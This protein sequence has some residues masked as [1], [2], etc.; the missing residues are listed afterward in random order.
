MKSDNPSTL[1]LAPSWNAASEQFRLTRIQ[2][3]NWGTFSGVHDFAIPREGYLFV[4]P[5][6]SGKSTIL[7]AHAALT[8]PPKWIELNVAARE[9]E[10]GKD[11]NILTYVR[12]AWSQQTSDSG[13]YVSQYLRSETTW[14]AIAETYCNEAGQVVVLAQALWVRGRS[15]AASDVKRHYLVLDREFDVRELQFLPEHDFDV[16]RFK[17]NLPGVFARDE[18]S[19]YQERFRRMLGIESDR[20]LRL[21]HKTQS[22]KNLGDLNTFLRDFMLDQP[23]TFELAD[24]LVTQF[25]ELDQ[26]HRAVV[27]A[28]RQVEVL[29]PAKEMAAELAEV[30]GTKAVLDALTEALDPYREQQRAI[31]FRDAIASNKTEASGLE[32]E[33]MRLDGLSSNEYARLRSFQEQRVGM[34]GGQ[35]ERL[36]EACSEA[37]TLRSKRLDRCAQMTGACAALGWAAPTTAA[38]FMQ[39]KNDAERYVLDEKAKSDT[40]EENKFALKTKMG[41]LAEKLSQARLEVG[42]LERQRSNIP[43][44]MLVL[45]ERLAQSLG[46]AEE[47]LPFAGELMEV[48]P[49]ENVWQGAIERVLHGFAISLLVE[50]RLY[51]Q[52]SAYLN[53]ANLGENLAYHR[54]RDHSQVP[55]SIGATS[56]VRKLKLAS[57]SHAAW[58]HNE[59]KAKFDFEC[60]DSMVAFRSAQRAVTREGQVKLSPTFHQKNDRTPVGDRT[61]WVLGFDNAAKLDLFRKEAFDLVVAIEECRKAVAALDDEASNERGR[62]RAC[63]L[64]SNLAWDDVDVDSSL[65]RI[66]ALEA[67]IE[68]EKAAHPDLALLDQRIEQQDVAYQKAGAAVASC[69]SKIEQ[70]LRRVQEM[71]SK[72]GAVRQD[73]LDKV[74]APS[75]I[76]Q[77][78][79]RFKC[80]VDVLKL[81]NIHSAQMQVDRTLNSERNSLGEQIGTLVHRIEQRFA[82]FVRMWPAEAGGLDATI[83]SAPD[84]FAKLTR[85][86]ADGLPQYESRFLELLREQSDQNLTRLATQYSLERKAIKDRMDLVNDSLATAPY[87]PGTHL[88]IEIQDKS[89]PDVIAFRQ[90]LRDSLSHSLGDSDTAEQ[91]F[92]VLNALVKRFA[93]QETPDKNWR[94]LVLDV[95]LHVEFIARELDQDGVEVEV[96]RSGAG[97]SGGQRQKL[98]ATCLAAALRYQLGGQDRALP[99]FS[100]VVMDEAFDKADAEFTTMAMNI[101]KTFG[102]Q[103]IVA[104]PLKSVMTLEPFIG[105]ACFVRIL[106][107]KV[108][109]PLFID[110]D[111]AT[112]RLLLPR[113][114]PDGEEALI[115]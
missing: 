22:A 61:R 2:T 67:Q 113:G 101:F 28:R 109:E 40:R 45:R 35:L 21:L 56:L 100:T 29:S 103:M 6:G 91:R 68:A 49:E 32:Q 12:G 38:A 7:D 66:A 104:T 60:V 69:V 1:M 62:Y 16:R 48:R 82:D 110:Y 80:V 96:Y 74:L 23:Q 58:V 115:A 8:T 90:G 87:N 84:F 31:L 33:K 17:F 51:P 63:M 83:A 95:R 65:A 111:K 42:M 43:A 55:S 114:L 11:R 46:I 73:L 71:E 85:L 24:K 4:G 81:D 86:E 88:V 54:M 105:G 3:F 102:F 9:T 99:Q 36:T 19:A 26:A 93:S 15:T 53:S 108:S 64:L 10:R 98:A 70:A 94:S 13:E 72:L 107:R 44:R 18:F 59:L 76:A 106:D 30:R 5:S 25:Q 37:Q 79:E 52:V 50:E 92:A 20:A 14:S 47:Q 97:K 41:R 77:L 112:Q 34:G 57:G 27:A 75:T 78:E 89:L 39:Q